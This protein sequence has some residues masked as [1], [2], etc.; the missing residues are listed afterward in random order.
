MIEKTLIPFCGYPIYK[1]KTGELLNEDE[2]NFFKSL[3]NKPHMETNISTKLT[4]GVNILNNRELYRIKG[5]IWNN[6]VDYVDDVLEIKNDFYTCNSWG[7]IQKKGDYHPNHNHQNSVF[8]SVFYVQASD[9]SITFT[10]DRSKIMEGFLFEYHIKN[11][12]HFNAL[13]WKVPVETGDLIIFPG[14][15]KHESQ[16][17]IADDERMIIGSSY[18]LKGDL[19]SD[20][21]YN[22]ISI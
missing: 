8:S 5:V 15:L 21:N 10:V 16:V 7:T 14:E 13:S 4:K 22:S 2:L 9:S 17:N 12:N 1:I 20:S 19:G 6:F 11:Y 18:F 3:D